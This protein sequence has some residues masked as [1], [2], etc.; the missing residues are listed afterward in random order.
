MSK[1][2]AM[3]ASIYIHLPTATERVGL[4]G[5]GSFLL[6]QSIPAAMV[7]ALPV[8]ADEGNEEMCGHQRCVFLLPFVDVDCG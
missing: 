3:F 4:L 6:P 1:S 8:V 5:V 2:N 7:L